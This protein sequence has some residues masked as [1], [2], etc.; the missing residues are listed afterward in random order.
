[1]LPAGRNIR[2][3]SSIENPWLPHEPDAGGYIGRHVPSR[4]PGYAAPYA[5]HNFEE[6]GQMRFKKRVRDG[7]DSFSS[8]Q[9]TFQQ[10]TKTGTI[11]CRRDIR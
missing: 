2:T 7:R 9:P 1:M 4:Q 6:V 3:S 8:A 11:M 10:T 5:R